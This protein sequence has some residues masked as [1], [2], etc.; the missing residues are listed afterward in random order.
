[1]KATPPAE[2]A[3]R[4]HTSTRL[5]TVAVIALIAVAIAQQVYLASRPA[6]AEVFYFPQQR[7]TNTLP[8][9][10]GPAVRVDGGGVTVR[11]TK[12]NHLPTPVSVSGSSAWVSLDPGG[13]IVTTSRDVPMQR[14]PGCVSRD[15]VNPIPVQ[16]TEATRRL[17]AASRRPCVTWQLT[18]TETPIDKRYLPA[19]WVTDPIQI[20]V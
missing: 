12:C 11:G 20:C 2:P 1:M 10:Q 19:V 13:T 15:Y 14:A 5:L 9:V 3:R 18:G 7:V 8:G 4:I 17:A 6:P 16:V